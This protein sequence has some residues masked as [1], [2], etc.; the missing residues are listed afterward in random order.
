[1]KLV[2]QVH[3]P[4]GKSAADFDSNLE[5]LFLWTLETSGRDWAI[6]DDAK[7]TY[8]FLENTSYRSGA[9]G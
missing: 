9:G 8:H 6:Y 7:P 5:L 2:N 3:K 1:M 4:S